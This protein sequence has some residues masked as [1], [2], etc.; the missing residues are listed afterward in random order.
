MKM[1][2]VRANYVINWF[3]NR[4]TAQAF[5]DQHEDAEV[6]TQPCTGNMIGCYG[7]PYVQFHYEGAVKLGDCSTNCKGGETKTLYTTPECY[8]KGME[9]FIKY[10]ANMK[11]HIDHYYSQP[12]V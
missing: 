6:E 4:E 5:A 3:F 8:D 11:Q 2:S 7:A 10:K 1:Y 12:W 9:E